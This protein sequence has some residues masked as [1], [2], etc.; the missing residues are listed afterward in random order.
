M[1]ERKEREEPRR[2]LL[3]ILLIVPLGVLCMFLTGQQAI[4][5]AP[6]W[7][8]VADMGSYLDPDADFAAKTNLELME[9]VNSDILTQPVWGD[10]F[11]T[12][13][14]VI[15]T[16]IAQTKVPTPQT[17]PTNQPTVSIP[18]NLP[19]LIPPPT[20]E[21]LPPTKPPPPPP[22]PPPPILSANLAISK[23]ASSAVYAPGAGIIYTIVETNA[24]PDDATGFNIT[25]SVPAEIVPATG[26]VITCSPSD[27][28]NDSCGTDTTSGRDVAF[29]GASLSTGETL[30]ITIQGVVGIGTAGDLS[31]TAN[32]VIPGG[33][34]FNDPDT[35]NNS[36]I[37]N[38]LAPVRPIFGLPDGLPIYNPGDG[39]PVPFLL[40]TPI[41]ASG[42]AT[43]DFIYFEHMYA[44]NQVLMDWVQVEISADGSTW[45]T[46]FFWGDGIPDTNT[47][48][49]INII[50]GAEDDNRAF[51]PANA[52]FYTS[53]APLSIS[54]GVTINIDAIPGITTG[55]DYY[56]IRITAPQVGGTYG[57]NDGLEVDAILPYFPP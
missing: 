52:V 1:T 19:T 44:P 41:N 28:V 56:W 15:P 2:E 12:P 14:A 55:T 18:T 3:L 8:M 25:D 21:V 50:G 29:N 42:D 43:P 31:N 6:S 39:V 10:L 27:P 36:D 49:N 48:L 57:G 22:P 53:P 46:V 20:I 4:K 23:S 33:A 7:T 38:T 32:L 40:P 5:L 26:L 11:L 51:D 13:N 35:S 45:F 34:G 30:T 24:G 16:R 17:L 9:P 54:S 47:N 37:E